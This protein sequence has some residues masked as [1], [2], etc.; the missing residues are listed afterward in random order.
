V[1]L[2]STSSSKN[3]GQEIDV[4]EYHATVETLAWKIYVSFCLEKQT[5]DIDVSP[6]LSQRTGTA[7]PNSS[8]LVLTKSWREIGKPDPWSFC[9]TADEKKKP[10]V[11]RYRLPNVAF[12]DYVCL[13]S[14]SLDELSRKISLMMARKRTKSCMNWFLRKIS[15]D[16]YSKRA[17]GG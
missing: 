2:K 8:E 1:R 10:S 13:L 3:D 9:K 4:L 12:S 11:N 14:F 16:E 15:G 7:Q 17:S 6:S 5:E